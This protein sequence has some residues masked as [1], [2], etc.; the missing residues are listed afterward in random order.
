MI[1]FS[2]VIVS[3]HAHLSHNWREIKQVSNYNFFVI[4]HLRHSHVKCAR[5][6]GFQ[7]NVFKTEG[8]RY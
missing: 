3:Q 4:G 8:K 2:I 6:D 7:L 1:E 5:F